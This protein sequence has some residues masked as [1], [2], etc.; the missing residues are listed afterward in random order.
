MH[1]NF[2]SHFP[3]NTIIPL[4]SIIVSAWATCECEPNKHVSH[5]LPFCFPAI[6]QPSSKCLPGTISCSFLQLNLWC[7]T[8]QTFHAKYI[9]QS[10][11]NPVLPLSQRKSSIYLSQLLLSISFIL[12]SPRKKMSLIFGTIVINSNIF[13]NEKAQCIENAKSLMALGI[14]LNCWKFSVNALHSHLCHVNMGCLEIRIHDGR[15]R[16]GVELDG[17]QCQRRVYLLLKHMW[18]IWRLGVTFLPPHPRPIMQ[19]APVSKLNHRLAT[20]KAY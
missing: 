15:C 18:V 16:N 6:L 1:I 8:K 3:P 2:Y 14:A 4:P 10:W 7:G 12:Q 9:S 20:D 13:C 11:F 19:K 5:I 17:C